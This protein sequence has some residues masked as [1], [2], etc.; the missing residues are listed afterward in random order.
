[1][2][3]I[4]KIAEIDFGQTLIENIFINDFMAMANGTHVKVYLV[5][6][7]YAHDNEINHKVNN[8]TIANDLSIPLVDV[9]GAWDFWESKNIIKKHIKTD[10]LD[11]NDYTVEFLSLRQLYIDNNYAQKNTSSS[12]QNINNENTVSNLITANKVPEVKEMFYEIQQLMR[13]PL[14]TNE[15]MKILDWMTDYGITPDVILRSFQY[16]IEQRGVK[17][18]SYTAA[19]IRSWYDKGIITIEKVDEELS[20][21]DVRFSSYVKILKFLGLNTNTIGDN[22]KNII[23]K[24]FD[25][26]GFSLEIILK[27]CE[28]SANIPNPNLKYIDK[29]LGDWYANGVRTLADVDARLN[30]LKKDKSSPQNDTKKKTLSKNNRFHNFEQ[31]YH[32]YSNDDFEK[33]MSNKKNK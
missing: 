2:S 9:L 29:I 4:K 32:T 6:F 8:Q 19:I 27:A 20:K 5:G 15:R 14:S 24:W 33:F 18:I 3:F 10:S 13:R 11:D 1:M 30:S 22:S 25:T 23:N 17:N 12:S 16:S 28:N 7:K 21:S 31:K 26:W